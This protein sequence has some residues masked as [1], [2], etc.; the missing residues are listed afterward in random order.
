MNRQIKFIFTCLFAFAVSAFSAN[1]EWSKLGKSNNRVSLGG[2][3]EYD[4]IYL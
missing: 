1:A 3:D 2:R 4:S